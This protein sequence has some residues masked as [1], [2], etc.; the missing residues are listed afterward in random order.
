LHAGPPFSRQR[1]SR[2]I[3]SGI[4]WRNEHR[5]CSMRALPERFQS[6]NGTYQGH[7][8]LVISRFRRIIGSG[9]L[10]LPLAPRG[11]RRGAAPAVLWPYKHAGHVA[12]TGALIR[13]Q[14]RVVL[15]GRDPEQLIHGRFASRARDAAICSA[16]IRHNTL[17]PCVQGLALASFKRSSENP[18]A[19]S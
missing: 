3:E 11:A 8:G 6:L 13:D 7:P 10:R 17:A 12:A 15:F 19:G 5:I 9:P 2:P 18:A 1:L 14:A 16:G 4:D